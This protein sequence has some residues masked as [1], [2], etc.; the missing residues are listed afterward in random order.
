MKNFDKS[1]FSKKENTYLSAIFFLFGISIMS[2][3]PRTPDLKANLA[4]N[5][6]TFGTLLSAASI[7]SIIMLLIGGQIVHTIGAK[8]SLQIGST[9]VAI[10]FI[11]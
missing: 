8:K 9:V 4:I 7:G 6:G 3:A 5:N 10:T 2:L 1:I 11:V